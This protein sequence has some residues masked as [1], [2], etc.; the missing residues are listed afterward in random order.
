[1]S[2]AWNLGLTGTK[3]PKPGRLSFHKFPRV[4]REE[5][6]IVWSELLTLKI[7]WIGMIRYNR[8]YNVAKFQNDPRCSKETFQSDWVW[9]RCDP[10]HRGNLFLCASL[11]VSAH[12][13]VLLVVEIQSLKEELFI[14]TTFT[15]PSQAPEVRHKGVP[16]GA[17]IATSR[18]NV[19]TTSRQRQ[20]SR[21]KL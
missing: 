7:H 18:S 4:H 3:I 10:K 5:C 11:R 13:C 2:R 8:L 20:S 16:A 21:R 17:T 14:F 12:L 19:E 15:S 9:S 6:L 1:M